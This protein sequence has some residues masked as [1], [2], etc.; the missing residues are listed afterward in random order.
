LTIHPYSPAA[1]HRFNQANLILEMHPMTCLVN[2]VVIFV[3]VIRTVAAL[4]VMVVCACHHR[5]PVSIRG[6]IQEQQM[7]VGVAELW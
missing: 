7:V 2:Q 1:R 3:S 5:H 6:Y 4:S